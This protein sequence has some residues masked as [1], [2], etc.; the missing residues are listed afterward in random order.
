MKTVLFA[1][2]LAMP[3]GAQTLDYA[4]LCGAT[5]GTGGNNDLAHSDCYIHDSACGRDSDNN[6]FCTLWAQRN[7][8]GMRNA[9]SISIRTA[10]AAENRNRFYFDHKK[11]APRGAFIQVRRAWMGDDWQ[12]R[13]HEDFSGEG[14]SCQGACPRL[15]TFTIHNRNLQPGGSEQRRAA[16]AKVRIYESSDEGDYE[17]E[18]RAETGFD[19]VTV[20][21]GIDSS[22]ALGKHRSVLRI[23]RDGVVLTAEEV[24]VFVECALD[25]YGWQ[26]G[27]VQERPSFGYGYRYTGQG[28]FRYCPPSSSAD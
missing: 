28:R 14:Y 7:Y 11:G 13:R 5:E 27:I 2:A 18:L 19:R 1:L 17:T 3:I 21:N 12:I 20:T 4:T 15:T 9:L 25:E 24:R 6:D 8:Q 10:R 26:I 22:A 16:V 23:K